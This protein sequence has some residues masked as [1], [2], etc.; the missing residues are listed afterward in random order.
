MPR[1]AQ[2]ADPLQ[3][4]ADLRAGLELLDRQLITQRPIRVAQP[5]RIDQLRMIQPARLQVSP[6]PPARPSTSRGSSR[7]PGPAAPRHRQPQALALPAK[8]QRLKRERTGSPQAPALRPLAAATAPPPAGTT[9]PRTASPSRSPTHRPGTRPGNAT[10]SSSDSPPATASCRR[11][12]DTA[13]PDPCRAG[14][15]SIPADSTSRS[16]DTRRFSRSI[17]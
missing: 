10:G 11:G 14:F 9:R 7:S 8:P 5:E 6:A 17:S 1:L 4:P 15:S 12:T 13:P 16:T 3:R 2:D